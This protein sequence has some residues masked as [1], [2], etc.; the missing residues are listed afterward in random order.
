MLRKL[1][2]D[3]EARDGSGFSLKAF[4]D[5]LLSQGSVPLWLHRTLM[6]GD[7]GD[8]LLD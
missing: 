6:L 8:E 5:K 2:A 1:R 3:L 7:T 4:H